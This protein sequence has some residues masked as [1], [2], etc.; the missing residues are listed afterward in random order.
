MRGAQAGEGKLCR[1]SR[2][3]RYRDVREAGDLVSEGGVGREGTWNG[4]GGDH[5]SLYRI[6]ISSGME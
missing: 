4:I 6:S 3:T 1:V 2:G 5:V